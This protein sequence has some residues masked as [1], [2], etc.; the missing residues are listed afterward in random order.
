[1]NRL[2]NESIF[3]EFRLLKNINNA[4]TVADNDFFV[5]GSFFSLTSK[6]MLRT[7]M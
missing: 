7:K 2:I 4:I 3:N 1:M 5:T 6:E